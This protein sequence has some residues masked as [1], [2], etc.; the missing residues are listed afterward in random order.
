MIRFFRWVILLG[1]LMRVA[2]VQA[3]NFE[4]AT[5][6]GYPQMNTNGWTL[7][8]MA[9]TGSTPAGDGTP[10]ELILTNAVNTTSGA[11]FFNTPVDISRC[12]TWVAEFDYRI[13]GGTGA[14]GIGFF[15][16]SNPP[17]GFVRGGGLGIPSDNRGVVVGLDTWQN[18]NCYGGTVPKLEIRYI[19]PTSNYSECPAGPPQPTIGGVTELRQPTYNTCTIRYDQGNIDV[20]INGILRLSGFYNIDFVGYFGLSASTGGSTD[21][22]SIKNFSLRTFRP[23]MSAPNP[24]PNITICNGGTGRLGVAVPPTDPY[25]YRWSPAT[26]LSDPNDPNPT[27]SLPNNTGTAQTYTYFL[28]KDTVGATPRC[29]FS[30]EVRVTVLGRAA[31]AGADLTLCSNEPRVLNLNPTTGY[32]YRWFPTTGLSNPFTA[33]PTLQLRNPTTSAVTYEYIITAINSTLG[34]SEQDT[35]KV[36]VLPE[37][38][39][40]GPDVNICSGQSASIGSAPLPNFLY[41]WSPATGLTNPNS[42]S[43]TLTLVNTTSSVVRYRYILSAFSVSA[44][45]STTDTVWVNVYPTPVAN[46]GNR[47]VQICHNASVT[48]GSPAQNGVSYSWS[49]AIG[50]NNPLLAQPR[51][52]GV[53]TSTA[54]I[55]RV[56]RLTATSVFGSCST[57]DSVT[58]TINPLP[59]ASA[60]ADRAVCH[61]D[62]TRLGA[63]PE[64][65][66]TYF[67]VPNIGLSSATVANPL[68]TV[69]NTNTGPIDRTF[70]LTTRLNG[71]TATDTV[72]VVLL[73]KPFAPFVVDSGA[74]CDGDTLT[75]PTV[76]EVNTTYRWEPNAVLSGLTVANPTFTVSLGNTSAVR[77]PLVLSSTLT[78][79]GCSRTDTFWVRVNPKPRNPYADV[80]VCA[81]STVTLRSNIGTGWSYNWQPIVGL[82]NPSAAAPIFTAPLVGRDTTLIYT[83]RLTNS[84]FPCTVL[85]TVR[86]RIKALPAANAGPDRLELCQGDSVQVGTPAVPGLTYR[87]SPSTGLN[88]ANIAQPLVSTLNAVPGAI[89][90]IL[91]VNDGTCSSTDT[92]LVL[93]KPKPASLLPNLISLCS[94]DTISIQNLPLQGYTYRWNTLNGLSDSTIANPRLTLVNNTDQD[95]V[96]YYV[97]QVDNLNN[98]C[99]TTDTMGVV[100]HPLPAVNAGADVTLCPDVPSVIG[101]AD[102]VQGYTYQ[103]SPIR[104]LSNPNAAKPAIQLGDDLPTAQ[105]YT[106]VLTARNPVTGCTKTDTVLV[107]LNPAPRIQMARQLATCLGDTVQMGGAVVPGNAYLWSP[108][109][110]LSATNLANPVLASSVLV[111]GTYVYRL[112]I[113][114]ANG[115]VRLDSQ[116]VAVAPLPATPTIVGRASLCPGVSGVGYKVA[117]PTLGTDYIWEVVGGSILNSTSRRDSITVAWGASFPTTAVRLRA[118]SAAGCTSLVATLRIALKRNLDVAAPRSSAIGAVCAGTIVTYTADPLIPF[119]NYTWVVSGGTIVSG[120]GTSQVAVNWAQ[121]GVGTV[122]ISERS[123]TPM[124]TCLGNSDTLAVRVNPVPVIQFTQADARPC[125]L[126]GGTTY[127]VNLIQGASYVW[128]VTNGTIVNQS[129]N[130][131]QI[132]FSAA[133]PATLRVTATS[134]SGCVGNDLVLNLDVRAAPV[135]RFTETATTFCSSRTEGYTYSVSGGVRYAWRVSGGSIT[136]YNADSSRVVVGFIPGASAY[137]VEVSSVD[138]SGCPSSPLVQLVSSEPNGFGLT[139]VSVPV[140]NPEHIELTYTSTAN[141]TRALVLQ[142]RVVGAAAFTDLVTLAYDESQYVDT[143]S[144]PASV[145]YQYRLRYISSCGDTLYSYTL[146]NMLI[147]VA[148]GTG[149]DV[150]LVTTQGITGL[151]PA[152]VELQRSLEG[153][154][155]FS[156]FQSQQTVVNNPVFSGVWGADGFTQCFRV[157]SRAQSGTGSTQSNTVCITLPNRPEAP[158]VVTPNGDGVN[159]AFVLDYLHLYPDHEIRV[160]NRYGTLMNTLKKYE[161]T[162]PQADLPAGTYFL[163]LNL[164]NGTTTKL[165]VEV[166]R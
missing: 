113:T 56:Y 49:P 81:G 71:C 51:L 89:T 21:M 165:W 33:N 132:A 156:P 163:F 31:T 17:R 50:L 62:T 75:I 104:G 5:L 109:L 38:A 120:Q 121:A 74:V 70:V 90:Y 149:K 2:C 84:G 80:Q 114:G 129:G 108:A 141:A 158:N 157:V 162:W 55:T 59:V 151:A 155:S 106:Y 53:N 11:V 147:Q 98:G 91:T 82:N 83:V 60:G 23:I 137:S 117:Q 36:T 64:P 136:A 42:A 142:R 30:A 35:L 76:L 48:L 116:V 101:S 16:L 103:W 18:G 131:A 93:L 140:S 125:L 161:G 115:C 32:T 126:G 29:A 8:G 123:Q 22:H 145:A 78:L 130:E 20:Y 134:D 4:F 102:S 97:L 96:Y 34:C 92:V 73:Q 37:A 110:G 39:N 9:Y 19:T 135:L 61:G 88:N 41:S 7:A 107:T 3:Q 79:N 127:R 154:N 111:P 58:I 119:S 68:L 144:Q 143:S 28:T 166:V 100:V 14:D 146:G 150:L 46:V 47:N 45:C 112:R 72:R 69:D 66:A 122:Y 99:S 65:G 128:S 124:D 152:E 13:W 10:S 24:G 67:W 26:G 86:I 25:V 133:G 138:T 148:Q 164:R 118:I 52:T 6:G 160:Y 15:F 153:I 95:T 43:T 44:V 27:I 159:D 105:Q 85:D 63:A 94:G 77:I 40:A 139:Q 57:V 87:W 1:L 54:P 12:Q